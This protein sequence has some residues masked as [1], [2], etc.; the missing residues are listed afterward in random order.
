MK[1]A[2]D[3]KLNDLLSGLAANVADALFEEMSHVEQ[4]RAMNSHFNVMRALKLNGGL[5]REE[6]GLLVNVS[7]AALLNARDKQALPD[8][9]AEITQLLSAYSERNLNH[10]TM[11]LNQI[12]QKF[13][14]LCQKEMS[15]HPLLPS[16]FYLCF[17][18]RDR[19]T[20][21]ILRRKRSFDS[22]CLIV[23]LW[24]ALVKF[25]PL[26]IKR[27]L[28]KVSKTTPTSLQSRLLPKVRSQSQLASHVQRWGSRNGS[29]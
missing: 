13:S 16:N 8:A 19:K 17:W 1:S 22:L 11:L 28:M 3:E 26:R 14:A 12:Q 2:V 4:Q 6:F 24:I 29:R 18:C 10:H 27:S 23:L 5:F 20:R 9:D 15:F 7:W 25:C 21:F